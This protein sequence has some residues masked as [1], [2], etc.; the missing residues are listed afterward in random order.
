MRTRKQKGEL[1]RKG[2]KW[3][4]RYFDFRVEGGQLMRKRLCKPLCTVA[5]MTKTQAREEAKR[6]LDTINNA[7]LAP[8]TAITLVDF[9][10]SVYI[11]RLKQDVRP[12]TYRGYGVLWA[13]L[14]P[15]CADYLT[16][17]IRTRHV[18]QILDEMARTD[19]FGKR[20]LQHLKFFL[21]GAFGLAIRND[22]YAGVNPAT[23]AKIPSKVRGA[24]E[25]FVY[26]LEE[27]LIMMDATPEPA[28]TLIAVAA[29]TALRRGEL[30]GLRWE[31]YRNGEIHVSRSIWNGH[32]TDPKTEESKNA[33]P[34]ISKLAAILAEHRKSQGSPI[35]G[36]IFPN[37]E[38]KPADPNNVLQRGIL[39]ALSVCGMCSKVEEEH[40]ATTGHSYERNTVL[41]QWRGWHAFRR[42]VA[43][44]LNRLGVPD[45]IIQR[46]LRHSDVAITQAAYIK[47][48]DKDSRNAMEKF[49]TA[50]TATQLP[51]KTR[52]QSIKGVM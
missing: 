8:E 32:E 39:P 9:I 52:V 4:L 34:V 3:Y 16:R 11:P 27:V 31:D 14:K 35:S 41:P 15:F 47:P 28:R 2:Q 17:D 26:S 45:K 37:G 42:G 18:Q 20:S 1:Y 38:G 21:A 29:F 13:A 46:V 36:W 43:T 25:T 23:E 50:L 7:V 24:G 40:N 30:R 10:D 44:N 5:D 22:Y 51:P 48:E 12:S 49:E 6:F 33:V 19:R